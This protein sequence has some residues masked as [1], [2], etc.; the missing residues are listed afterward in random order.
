MFELLGGC[1][2]GLVIA[3]FFRV[4]KSNIESSVT[5]LATIEML[6]VGAITLDL[7]DKIMIVVAAVAFS[8]AIVFAKTDIDVRH[9]CKS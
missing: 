8:R 1:F 4:R 5:K 9:K 6:L 3:L 2:G 7:W